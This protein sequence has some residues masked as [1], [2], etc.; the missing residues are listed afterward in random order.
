MLFRSQVGDGPDVDPSPS[1]PAVCADR[2]AGHLPPPEP[3]APLLAHPFRQ[4]HTDRQ[5]IPETPRDVWTSP[6][7]EVVYVYETYKDEE[8]FE[9]HKNNEPFKKFDEI[10]SKT[11]IEEWGE[12]IPFAESVTS[13]VDE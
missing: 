3:C 6:E 7:P 10:L 2:R 12:A 1:S 11:M 5:G 8:A 4:I 9:I 13:N